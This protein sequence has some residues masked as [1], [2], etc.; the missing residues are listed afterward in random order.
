MPQH[1]G[2][3]HHTV[4]RE[5]SGSLL[6]LPPQGSARLADVPG[7]L[8]FL[9]LVLTPVSRQYRL[10]KVK[11]SGNATCTLPAFQKS[12]QQNHKPLK[13]LFFTVCSET[14]SVHFSTT[15]LGELLFPHPENPLRFWPSGCSRLPNHK[16]LT[17]QQQAYAKT[18]P[19]TF[20][21]L[22]SV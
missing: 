19:N 1:R 12:Q 2:N 18:A 9:R 21:I 22:S 10:A 3:V 15:S 17:S 5:T 4:P 16:A 7:G 8:P 14:T 6:S 11:G 20:L 13:K